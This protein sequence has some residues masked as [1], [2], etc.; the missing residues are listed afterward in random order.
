VVSWSKFYNK[1]PEYSIS[2]IGS[3]FGDVKVADIIRMY[4]D[5][6]HSVIN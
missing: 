5:S 4:I 3:V 1:R 6:R 2:I